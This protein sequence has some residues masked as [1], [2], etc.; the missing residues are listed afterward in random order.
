MNLT[1]ISGVVSFSYKALT[2]SFQ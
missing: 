2:T 1:N